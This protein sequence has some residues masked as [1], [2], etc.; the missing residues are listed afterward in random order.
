M[1]AERRGTAGAAELLIAV[2]VGQPARVGEGRGLR[3]AECAGERPQVTYPLGPG[4]LDG[5]RFVQG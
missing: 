1:P 5:L 4:G 3:A 2:P